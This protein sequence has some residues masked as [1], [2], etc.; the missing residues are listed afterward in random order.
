MKFRHKDLAALRL[1][2]KKSGIKRFLLESTQDVRVSAAA[3]RGH[4]RL[5]FYVFTADGEQSH[6]ST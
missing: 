2:R 6:E 5:I 3:A 1:S 4:G